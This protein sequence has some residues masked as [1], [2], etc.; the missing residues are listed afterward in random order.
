MNNIPETLKILFVGNSF[1][2]DTMHY[3]AQVAKALGV[4][5]LKFA[6]LYVG[7][8][9]ID[10][11]Y[12]HAVGDV[13]AYTCYVN[14]GEGWTS[15]PDFKISDAVKSDDWDWIAIQHGTK[16]T[17]RYT[18]VECY[19][20]LDAL[21]DYIKNL[22][23]EKTKIAFNMTWIGEPTDTHHEIVSYGGDVVE[24][25]RKLVEVKKQ[26]ILTNRKIDLF[27]PTGTAIEN[28]R[29]SKIGIL[30]RDGYHL[31]LDKGRFIAAL[32][33]ISTVTDADISE[34]SWTPDGVDEYALSVAIESVT[35][36]RT[37]PLDIINSKL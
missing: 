5:K 25:R 35:N 37:A 1:A 12:E 32:C 24:M 28:A 23:P 17:S 31:S 9:S 30:T 10:M 27:V 4:K 7:G 19:D 22:A 29:T 11:H 18:S 8:C 3:S 21:I 36:A 16:G 34:F 20:K 6:T 2:V 14:E 33:F 26:V 15:T 13:G